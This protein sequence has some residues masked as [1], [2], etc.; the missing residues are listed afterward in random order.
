MGSSSQWLA[1]RVGR[2]ARALA[3][4]R[5]RRARSRADRATVMM[6][7]QLR[8]WFRPSRCPTLLESSPPRICLGQHRLAGGRPRAF[9]RARSLR[10]VGRPS[11]GCGKGLKCPISG[12]LFAQWRSPADTAR[13]PCA[14]RQRVSCDAPAYRGAAPLHVARRAPLKGATSPT[15][16]P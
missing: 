9:A 16:S 3:S 15:G 12:T 1:A 7:M 2:G 4:R 5:Q 8:S 6:E 13:P 11:H 10:A 14:R